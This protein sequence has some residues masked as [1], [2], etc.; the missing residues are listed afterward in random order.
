MKTR[1]ACA[2]FLLANLSPASAQAPAGFRA[3]DYNIEQGW[4]TGEGKVLPGTWTIPVLGIH[5]H[6]GAFTEPFQRGWRELDGVERVIAGQH[7]DVVTMEEVNEPSIASLFTNQAD[8]LADR[9][10]MHSV[11]SVATEYGHGI[12]KRG[13]DAIL[14]KNPIDR[15]YTVELNPRTATTQRRIALFAHT[16]APGFPGGIWVVAAHTEPGATAVA[17]PH[18]V[19]ALA[20]LDA[21]FVLG[22]DLNATPGTPEIEGIVNGMAAAGRPVTDCWSEAGQGPG[23]T[24]P[25]QAPRDRQSYLFHSAEFE[26]TH[27]EVDASSQASGHFPVIADLQ[28]RS[29]ASAPATPVAT[30]PA[31]GAIGLLG[32]AAVPVQAP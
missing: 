14:S 18:L 32:V 23:L 28:S 9:L 31:G 16:T 13:G 3:M 17:V 5:I 6:H 4:G 11:S 30:A 22:G 25:S 10:H 26:A 2:L 27:A 7:P 24:V 12:L 29:L 8:Y 15:S 1:L 20:K 21:P 19:A